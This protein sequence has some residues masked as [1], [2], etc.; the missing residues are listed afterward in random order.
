MN[1]GPGAFYVI[2]TVITAPAKPLLSSWI[3]P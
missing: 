1:R 3:P 2:S